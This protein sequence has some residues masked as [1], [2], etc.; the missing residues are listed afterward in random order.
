[1]YC[2]SAR[3]SAA[4]VGICAAARKLGL[5]RVEE[6]LGVGIIARPAH[7][8]TLQDAESREQRAKWRPHVLRP[9]IAMKDEIAR[10]SRA[11]GTRHNGTRDGGAPPRR[12]RPGEDAARVLVHHDREV[13]PL[14]AG[15]EI[16]DVAD[17][18][19]IRAR[20]R[21]TPEPIRVPLIESVDRHFRAIPEYG[22]RPQA[23]LT[24]ETGDPTPAHAPAGALQQLMQAW[25]S[26]APVVQG[27]QAHDLVAEGPVLLCMRAR[28]ATTPGIEA[29]PRH[30]K[31]AAQGRHAVLRPM[32]RDEGED[33]AFRAEQNRMAFF[34]RSCSCS[35]CA[36][37]RSS[38]CSCLSS[39]TGAGGGAAGGFPRNRPSRTSFRHFESMKG[40]IASAAATVFT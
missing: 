32:R 2:W 4:V 14:T 39:R 5:E 29:R 22:R 25:T 18:D 17:P 28:P 1:M 38:A 13:P 7:A 21:C 9:A 8:R 27:K 12:E 35:S 24:H 26:V 37:F 10:P 15:L 33:V 19:L 31:G 11:C 40:W 36:Y 16:R 23:G 3:R 20:H 34:R 6:R 30:A